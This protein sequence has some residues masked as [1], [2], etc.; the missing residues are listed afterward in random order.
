MLNPTKI[1]HDNRE[2]NDMGGGITEFGSN[3]SHTTLAFSQT[4]PALDLNTFAFI[5]LILCHI[6]LLVLFGTAERRSGQTDAV[7]LAV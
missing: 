3:Q 2:G 6:A 4:E 5:T 1:Q 7:Q